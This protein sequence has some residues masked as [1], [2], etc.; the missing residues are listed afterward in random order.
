MTES[1]MTRQN[2]QTC[3]AFLLT[4]SMSRSGTDF[5]NHRQTKG[6]LSVKSRH[7]QV[8]ENLRKSVLGS[9]LEEKPRFSVQ[10]FGSYSNSCILGSECYFTFDTPGE[11]HFQSRLMCLLE[12][13]LPAAKKGRS[14]AAFY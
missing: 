10:F 5:G 14:D 8:E 1:E 6:V 11:T 7:V 3:G 12:T 9:V 13:M 2:S 4:Y